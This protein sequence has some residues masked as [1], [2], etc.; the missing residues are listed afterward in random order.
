MG[1]R[2]KYDPGEDR[3]RLA[4]E[5]GEG[6]PLAFWVTRRQW[7]GLLHTLAGLPVPENTEAE[8]AG[9]TVP[10]S[11]QHRLSLAEATVPTVLQAI[12]LRRQAG[13]IKLALITA[14][15]SVAVDLPHAGIVQ[16]QA[17]LRQQAERA[18]WDVDA[19]LARLSAASLADAAMKKARRLH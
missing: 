4:L 2:A 18:G 9:V 11:R 16:L 8:E 1:L 7:L 10:S 6:P 13:G 3:M 14:G 19:G 12:R 17:M 15:Q 5:P